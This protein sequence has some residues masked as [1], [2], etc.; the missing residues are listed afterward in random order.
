LHKIAE[1]DILYLYAKA[2]PCS[3]SAPAR[4]AVSP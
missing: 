3:F 4:H 1:S 2:L